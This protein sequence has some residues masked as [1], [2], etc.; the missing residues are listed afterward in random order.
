MSLPLFPV[1]VGLTWKRTRT[2]LFNTMR[3][4][5]VAGLEVDYS[6]RQRPIYTWDLTYGVLRA[7]Y[8]APIPKLGRYANDLQVPN[9]MQLYNVDTLTDNE[10]GVMEGFFS[11]QLGS[12]GSFLL[13]DPTDCTVGLYRYGRGYAQ[14]T[15][16][17]TGFDAAWQAAYGTPT[18]LIDQPPFGPLATNQF[19]V[20]TAASIDG[21]GLI[22]RTSPAFYGQPLY[23]T[24]PQ[25][26]QIGMPLLGEVFGTGDGETTQFQLTRTIGGTATG[27]AEQIKNLNAGTGTPIVWING[28][29]QASSA[30]SVNSLGL[31]TFN[32][33]PADGAYLTWSGKFYFY[34]R[35]NDDSLDL[36]E[37]MAGLYGIDGLKLRS[38]LQ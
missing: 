28:V 15:Q 10:E 6:L 36:D 20:D 14:Q 38:L 24:G 29:Q 16:W 18:L 5:S 22:T 4:Q 12:G 8:G 13:E 17:Q 33:A 7:Q 35:F 11:N 26:S 23:V 3:Q 9:L 1:F 19:Q 27:F 34:V 25:G 2:P 37:M 30:Y 21:N 31:V 32:S